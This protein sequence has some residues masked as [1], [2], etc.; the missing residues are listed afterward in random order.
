MLDIRSPTEADTDTSSEI[1]QYLFRDAPSS[2][3]KPTYTPYFSFKSWSRYRTNG[4]RLIPLGQPVG[5]WC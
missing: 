2:S 3:L 4:F 1:V 5:E